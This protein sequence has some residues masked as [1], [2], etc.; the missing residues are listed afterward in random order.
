MLFVAL[1][2]RSPEPGA[3][4]GNL[5]GQPRGGSDGVPFP[6]RVV[7]E[8]RLDGAGAGAGGVGPGVMSVDFIPGEPNRPPLLPSPPSPS[9]SPAP[10]PSHPPARLGFPSRPPSK[11]FLRRRAGGASSLQA[12]GK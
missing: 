4:A 7:R 9:H 11:P 5:T 6:L 8:E 3:A 10:S 2:S 1:L 12:P